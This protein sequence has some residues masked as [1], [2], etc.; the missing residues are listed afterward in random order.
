[1]EDREFFLIGET[2]QRPVLTTQIMLFQQESETRA[3]MFHPNQ[4]EK[5]NSDL[6]NLTI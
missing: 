1:M 6:T 5:N 3:L 4:S 2:L